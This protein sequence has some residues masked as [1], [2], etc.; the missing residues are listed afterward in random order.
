MIETNVA[1]ATMLQYQ[2]CGRLRNTEQF[3][4]TALWNKSVEKVSLKV[5]GI[6][7]TFRGHPALLRRSLSVSKVVF[8]LGSRARQLAC[9]STDTNR[10]R[11]VLD[12]D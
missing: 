7:W 1:V 6:V 3:A 12:S 2:P 4:S 5:I 8:L 10:N 11:S 9:D